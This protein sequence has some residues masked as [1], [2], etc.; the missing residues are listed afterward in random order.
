MATSS[1]DKKFVIRDEESLM[2]LIAIDQG[3]ASKKPKNIKTTTKEEREEGV[4]LLR[5]SLRHYLSSSKS[6]TK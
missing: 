2:R 3:P 6:S 4:R 1:F 5:Q